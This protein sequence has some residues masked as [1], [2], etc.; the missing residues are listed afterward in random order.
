MQRAG[1]L[2]GMNVARYNMASNN[3]M[4]PSE[5]VWSGSPLRVVAGAMRGKATESAEHKASLN[6]F[7]ASLQNMS[8]KIAKCR[9][10]L[11]VLSLS[12]LPLKHFWLIKHRMKSDA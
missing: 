11:T 7:F 6:F 4:V 8:K 2:T 9:F 5:S 10:D 12:L 3:R 1:L